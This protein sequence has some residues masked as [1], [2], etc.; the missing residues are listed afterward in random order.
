M[1]TDNVYDSAFPLEEL[2]ARLALEN[3]LAAL[4]S[5]L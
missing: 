3:T 2:D 5:Y 4:V 1:S